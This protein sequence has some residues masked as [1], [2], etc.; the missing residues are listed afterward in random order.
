M[1]QMQIVSVAHESGAV[2]VVGS[3]RI[4]QRG[5]VDEGNALMSLFDK[6]L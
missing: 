2:P 1:H 6:C 4:G 5:R 3:V